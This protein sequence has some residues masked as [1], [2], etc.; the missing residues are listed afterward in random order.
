MNT[1]FILFVLFA[2]GATL[3]YLRT[4]LLMATVVAGIGL[5]LIDEIAVAFLS[6]A[7][8]TIAWLGWLVN[9]AE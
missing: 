5:Y 9:P 2:G 4:P 8:V 6:N 1:L 3:A 7:I